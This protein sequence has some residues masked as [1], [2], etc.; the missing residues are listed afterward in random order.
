M[1]QLQKLLENSPSNSKYTSH[2]IQKEISHILSSRMKTHIREEIG[3]SKFF[4]VVDEARD[5][6]KKEQMVLF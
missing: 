4:I 2:K 6:Y 5:E 1:L 3:D